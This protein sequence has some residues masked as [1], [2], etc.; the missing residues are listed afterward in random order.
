[1]DYK[2][3]INDL[4]VICKRIL[5]NKLTGIYLHGSMAMGCFNAD[6]SDIDIIVIIEDNIMVE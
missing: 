5:G 1:M 2:E 4:V 6:K 3:L